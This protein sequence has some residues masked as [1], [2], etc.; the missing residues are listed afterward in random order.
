MAS[1]SFFFLLCFVLFFPSQDEGEGK[2]AVNL[3]LLAPSSHSFCTCW[4]PA[5]NPSFLEPTFHVGILTG[6]LYGMEV[7]F[8]AKAN[9]NSVESLVNK[10]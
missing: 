9:Q 3:G 7:V 8:R 10:I 1:F 2:E 5:I 6:R 4:S